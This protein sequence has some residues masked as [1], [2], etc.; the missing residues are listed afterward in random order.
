VVKRQIITLLKY[1]L[2]L[3]ILAWVV[4]DYWD[5]KSP[6]GE[7]VGLSA[8]L[9]KPINWLP[10]LLAF[11]ICSASVLMTFLRWHL[12][13]RAQDLPFTRANAIRLGMVG[14][15]F[16]TMLPGAVGGDIIKVAVLVREQSRR[17]VAVATVLIDRAIGLCGL[18]Y[19]AALLGGIFWWTGRLEELV[20]TEA[21]LITLEA[22]VTGAGIITGATLA[23]W[24]L[25]GFLPSR[26]V[27]IFA[28]RLLKIPKIGASLAEFWRAV[29]LYR[30]RSR[31]VA[32]AVGMA[33]LG[34]IGFVF[35]FYLAAQTL[36]PAD[37]IPSLGAHFLLVPVGM[38]AKASFP[39]PGGV[40]GA[41]FAFGTLYEILG[42]SFAFG[43]LGMLTS[44]VIAEWFLGSLCYLMYLR[45]KPQLAASGADGEGTGEPAGSP[46]GT[47]QVASS[48]RGS[49]Q[50]A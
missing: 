29:W 35:A 34:H 25:L 31:Q 24:I 9:E 17:T 1:G 43:V 4:C 47:D 37:Q 38:C 15:F 5:L 36:T 8:A 14:Y 30:C 3:G 21:A 22:I 6:S 50:D 42:Y 39:A 33:M 28:G 45:M 19:L 48:A 40:G 49:M 46:A 18:I 20:T 26:R 32:L 11:V 13:V 44:R 7:A 41:E 16:N 10:P 23:V 12:L 2:G 27:E